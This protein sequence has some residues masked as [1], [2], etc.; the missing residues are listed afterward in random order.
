MDAKHSVMINRNNLSMIQL[1]EVQA[2]EE[3]G[4]SVDLEDY[5]SKILENHQEQVFVELD[6]PTDNQ[7]KK[8]PFQPESSGIGSEDLNNYTIK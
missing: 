1:V 3:M 5:T 6:L 2:N 4:T 7:V 8:R